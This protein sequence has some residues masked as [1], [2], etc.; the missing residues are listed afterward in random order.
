MKVMKAKRQTKW[1]HCDGMAATCGSGANEARHVNMR[2]HATCL[3]SLHRAGRLHMVRSTS[4]ALSVGAMIV[5]QL[6]R[7]A[8]IKCSQLAAQDATCGG[9]RCAGSRLVIMQ[10]ARPEPWPPLQRLR[11]SF[12]LPRA[13]I[14]TCPLRAPLAA[15]LPLASSCFC[16]Q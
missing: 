3:D 9:G 5:T 4:A 14:D 13:L 15:F 8:S 16:S 6:A 2:R 10:V 1:Q 7:P 12:T 11:T